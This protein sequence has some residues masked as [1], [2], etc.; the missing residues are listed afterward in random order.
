MG[1]VVDTDL[2][3]VGV[4]GLRVVDTSV[5]PVSISANVQVAVYALAEQAAE[6]ILSN[7]RLSW[8]WLYISFPV[9]KV[10]VVLYAA[11]LLGSTRLYRRVLYSLTSK[12]MV[13]I[14]S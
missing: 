7:S 2:R 5:F 4:S 1:S 11:K 14:K 6:I 9:L 13:I 10:C 8:G 12:A 3:V